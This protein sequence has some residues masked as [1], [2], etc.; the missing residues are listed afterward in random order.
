MQQEK[1]KKVK[2]WRT[3]IDVLNIWETWIQPKTI[4]SCQSRRNNTSNYFKI[5]DSLNRRIPILMTFFKFIWRNNSLRLS[6]CF[7]T[8]SIFASLV[9]L[10]E[11]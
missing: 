2:I 9:D 11:F 7:Q 10:R 8:D 6:S 3:W 1:P 5:R 4:L